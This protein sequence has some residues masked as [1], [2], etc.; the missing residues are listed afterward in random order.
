VLWVQESAPLREILKPMLKESQSLYA[1][2]LVRA[3]ALAAGRE[4]SFAAGAEVVE[5][6]LQRMGV[7]RGTYLYADA[8]GLSRRNLVSADSLVRIL[9]FQSR[10]DTWPAFYDALP[11]AGVDGTLARRLKGTRAENNLRAKTGSMTGVFAVAGYLRTA[12]GERLALAAIANNFL[13]SA[14]AAAYAQ[15]AAAERLANFTRN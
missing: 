7:A 5:E 15:D 9:K 10:V 14:R 11:I 4:G 13:V 3:L 12:D 1:E 2:T 6:T 8:C